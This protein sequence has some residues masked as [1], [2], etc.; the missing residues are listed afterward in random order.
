MS[1]EAPRATVKLFFREAIARALTE[2]MRDDERVMVLGQDVGRF[3]GSYK[4]FVGLI[5]AF[6]PERVRDTPVAE[7]AMIGLGVGAAAAGM[8]PLVSITYMDFLM[9][10][11]DP[12]VNYAAKVRYKT[13]GQLTAPVVVKTTA[14]AK[15]QGVAH[16]QCIEAWLMGV[17]GLVVVAPST[18]AD[19]Y[20]LLKSA[21]RAQGPVVFVDHKRLFPTAGEVPVDEGSV[22]IGRAVVR[23][24]G[25]DVT[26]AT[27]SYMTRVADEAASRLAAEGVSCEIVDLRTL[28]PLDV[29]TVCES[30]AATGALVTLEE[31]QTACGVGAEISFRV[32]EAL[33]DV[34]VARIGALPA[35]VSSNPILES[36]CLPD[37]ERIAETV[38]RLL[39][40]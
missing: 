31:G 12:L 32:R 9:L 27:H 36:A 23:R 6:G 28:A 2:A 24:R 5:D 19:A 8:R 26:I 11:L 34:R 7:A 40:S 30:V 22:P 14:G 16:S 35:P 38:R 20:G 18:P 33:P 15:G 37:A 4:E 21:L 25:T 13:G 29:A 1:S 39:V 17:P 10:G 3:G